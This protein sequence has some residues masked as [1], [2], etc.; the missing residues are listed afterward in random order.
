LSI[1]SESLG[2]QQS[3]VADELEILR[4]RE[5]LLKAIDNTHADMSISVANRFP[6]IGDWLARRH[7]A[8][9]EDTLAESLF[10]LSSFAWGGETLDIAELQ[11]PRRALGKEYF[12]EITEGGYLLQ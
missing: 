12:L 11:L 5:V 7:E 2:M 8:A 10:G 4:S 3:I 9:E 6:L 1:L